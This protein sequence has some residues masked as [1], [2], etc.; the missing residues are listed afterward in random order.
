MRENLCVHILFENMVPGTQ[1]EEKILKQVESIQE[2]VT[3]TTNALFS[4]DLEKNTMNTSQSHA[5]GRRERG[6][7]FCPPVIKGCS[8]CL[9]SIQLSP[10]TGLYICES[11]GVSHMTDPEE[12]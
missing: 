4:G 10:I 12:P 9:L 3:Y 2:S 1:S 7:S 11:E 5:P 6:I 8:K